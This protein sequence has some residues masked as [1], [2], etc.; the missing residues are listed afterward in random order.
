M[1]PVS[2]SAAQQPDDSCGAQGL[3]EY[4]NLVLERC[5]DDQCL[6]LAKF[7]HVNKHIH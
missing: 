2:T 4:L 6:V 3:A 7:L 1:A 5:S